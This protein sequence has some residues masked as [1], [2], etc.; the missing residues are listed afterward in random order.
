MHVN[1]RLDLLDQ[2]DFPESALNELCDAWHFQL[3]GF[4]H[5]IDKQGPR[6]EVRV[7]LDVG[8]DDGSLT[9]IGIVAHGRVQLFSALGSGLVL[10]RAK[11]HVEHCVAIS[12]LK[13]GDLKRFILLK[14]IQVCV[15]TLRCCMEEPCYDVIVS[16][17]L[18]VCFLLLILFTL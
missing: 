14:F 13:D 7:I 17:F 4:D 6:V 18:K 15:E 2:I 1:L 11:H 9:Q 16:D 5:C 12:V 3:D 8:K 10:I